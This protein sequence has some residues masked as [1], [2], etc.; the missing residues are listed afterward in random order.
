MLSLSSSTS[1]AGSSG[2]TRAEWGVPK[3]PMRAVRVTH[4]RVGRRMVRVAGRDS[5][6]HFILGGRDV[7]MLGPE[8]RMLFGQR[9]FQCMPTGVVAAVDEFGCGRVDI[10]DGV[11]GQWV[12]DLVD[13]HGRAGLQ[14]R[15]LGDGADRPGQW[16]TPLRPDQLAAVHPD[17][18]P[19]HRRS[20]PGG[21]PAGSCPRPDTADRRSGFRRRRATVGGW[22][23]THRQTHRPSWLL[24]GLFRK[25]SPRSRSV[26]RLTRGP[27]PRDGGSPRPTAAIRMRGGDTPGSIRAKPV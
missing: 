4:V 26:T 10:K 22:R 6:G 16:R 20:R 19:S 18:T 7:E 24:S 25:V 27:G 13:P 21:P 11:G 15:G 14:A 2:C 12:D 17:R 3:R 8:H 23:R 5:V 1:A 9:G